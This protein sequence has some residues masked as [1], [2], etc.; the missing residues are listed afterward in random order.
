MYIS[1]AC[2]WA[3]RTV[4]A[5]KLKGL[6]DIIGLTVVDWLL[7]DKGWK[8]NEP[9]P[10]NGKTRLREIYELANPDYNA[11]WTV[12]ILWDKKNKT[13]VSNESA[14]ILRFMGHAF[15]DLVDDKYRKVDLYPKELR[16]QI[17]EFLQWV[18]DDINNGVYKAG[19]ASTQEAY[20]QNVHKLFESL[21]RVEKHLAASDGPYVFG[22]QLTEADIRL[23]TTIIRFD[24][25]YVQHFKCNISMIR[26]GF[27]TIHKWLRNLYWN[28]PAFKDTTDFDHIK[29][30]Y[31]KSHRK[32]NP[33]GI[34]P[35]GPVPNILPLDA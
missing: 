11:R 21:G 10:I 35:A 22:N 23:Y 16:S 7:D 26:D 32:I 25:V 30:H 1:W 33:Y 14:E 19:F 15:D 6:E 28:H 2:P 5:R 27:P 20:D 12:P 34:T 9:D 8:F 31:T 13:I 17:D 4:I 3:H 24:P 29:F 18:Y